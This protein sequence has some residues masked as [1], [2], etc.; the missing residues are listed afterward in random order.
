MVGLGRY[1]FF[2]RLVVARDDAHEVHHLRQALDPGMVIEAVDGP[3]VQ[4]RAGF[5]Q[6]RGR[7][8]G[9]QHEPHIH[10]QLLRGLEHVL[11]AVGAHDVGNLMGVGD[12]GGGAVGQD[13]FHELPGRD[14]GAFQVDVGVQKAGEDDLACHIG[15]HR[16]GVGAHAHDEALCH[17]NVRRAE[18]VCEHIDIGG[19]FQHQVRRFP[20]RRRVDNAPLFQQLAVDFARVAFRHRTT[21]SDKFLDIK[22]VYD[23]HK[24]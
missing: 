8:A 10:R 6:R 22:F 20:A 21:P 11:N 24:R 1:D 19:V 3:V 17:G 15:L 4:H 18:L 23:R 16:A 5:V 7:D 14:Q 9:G 12:D 2:H 13:R